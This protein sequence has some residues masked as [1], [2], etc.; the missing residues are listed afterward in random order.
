MKKDRLQGWLLM[1]LFEG[2]SV[3]ALL[4]GI[5]W[6]ITILIVFAGALFLLVNVLIIGM[7]SV[8]LQAKKGAKQGTGKKRSIREIVVIALLVICAGLAVV[9]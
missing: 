8:L 9:F 6:E 1:L 2:I 3:G 5:Y 4:L 7:F